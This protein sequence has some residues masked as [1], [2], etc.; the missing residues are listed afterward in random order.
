MRVVLVGAD[1]EENLGIG[2]IGAVAEAAGHEVTVVPFDVPEATE[3]VAREIVELGPDVVGLAIQ[4]QHRAAEFLCLARRVRALGYAGHLTCGGHFPSLAWRE[5]LEEDHGLDSV[6]LHEGERSFPDLVAAVEHGTALHDVHGLALRGH[7]GAAM[8][9]EARAL[10]D[11]LDEHP[12]ALRYRP[13]TH[14]V[15]I[16]FFPMIGGRGCWG[17]CAFCS[18]TTMYRDARAYGGGR[19][20]RLRSPENIAAEMAVLWHAAGG[21]GI[22]CFHDDNLLLPRPKDSLARISELRRALD[23]Y[24]V[25]SVALVGK[26][27]PDTVE[28]ALMRSLRDL[29][30]VRLYVG[31]E[32]ASQRGAD[33]LNRRTQRARVHD[34]LAACRAADIFVCYNLLLFEPDATL[35]DIRENIAFI[36]DNA[37]HPVNFCRAEPYYGTPLQLRVAARQELPGSYLGYN[38]RIEDDETELLF[39]VCAAAFRQRNFDT[40]GVANRSMGIGYT[41]KI[42]EQ[43]Y[44]DPRGRRAELRRRADD[45]TRQIT[46]ETAGFL[47]E[48]L[49]IVERFGRRNPDRVAREAALLGLRIAAADRRKHMAL[50]A[51]YADMDR[52]AAG[53]SRPPEPPR[54]P[55]RNLLQLAQSVALGAS[56]AMS[57]AHFAACGDDE[58]DDPG[59]TFPPPDPVPYDPPARLEPLPLPDPVPNEIPGPNVVD[60]VPADWPGMTL[61]PA[62]VDMDTNQRRRRRYRPNDPVG[63]L[64][65]PDPVPP[66]VDRAPPPDPVPRPVDPPP[67]P[68]RTIQQKG[69]AAESAPGESGH[70]TD[71]PGRRSLPIDQWRNTEAVRTHRSA[72]LPLHAPP[73]I[74]LSARREGAAVHVTLVGPDGPMSTRWEAAG[75]VEGE[76]GHVVWLPDSRSDQLRVAVRT[77]G[78]VAVTSLRASEI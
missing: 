47:D 22:F 61:D 72:D 77:S 73:A 58:R 44:E 64:P 14:H 51:I 39:R 71:A 42:V 59:P 62:P 13:N 52:F 65:R 37:M 21:A 23:E 15:G 56:L 19:T 2:M 28:P 50:D 63:M 18:I 25:G 60:P 41:L 75:S 26:C 78:G 4:F 29:G 34:A 69:A 53:A 7:D 9:T 45:L 40:E 49:E 12:F 35:D 20:L 66:P 76:G 31:V 24:G 74:T 67:A 48:A 11:D 54:H 30:V 8:R 32:N 27:R 17:S 55:T 33:H 36:R 46:G 3:E 43:F 38:Y 1:F 6:V 57:A 68:M 10:E 16:P 70:A 5:V